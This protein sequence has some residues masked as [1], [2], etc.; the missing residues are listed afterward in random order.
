LLL[1]SPAAKAG[2]FFLRAKEG[3]NAILSAPAPPK[4]AA[5]RNGAGSIWDG[6]RD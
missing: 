5:G 3:G 1:F 2:L 4:D 6:P